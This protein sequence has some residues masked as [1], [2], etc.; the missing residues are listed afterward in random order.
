MACYNIATI[1]IRG[2]N[3][4]NKCQIA[5]LY[6]EDNLLDIIFIQETHINNNNKLKN[7]KNIF[8]N[9]NVHYA[10]GENNSRGV[11]VLFKNNINYSILNENFD[12]DGRFLH[13]KISINNI[14]LNLVNIYAPNHSDYQLDFIEK[15]YNLLTTIHEDLIIGGDFNAISSIKHDTCNEKRKYLKNYE[16]EWLNLFK[17]VQ[18][19][20]ANESYLKQKHFNNKFITWSNNKAASRIDRLYFIANKNINLKYKDTKIFPQS[21]HRIVICEININKNVDKE[22]YKNKRWILNDSILDDEY[23]DIQIKHICENYKNNSD[24]INAYDIFIDKI[25]TTLK[26]EAKYLHNECKQRLRFL[27]N[28]YN[29]LADYAG[30]NNKHKRDEIKNEIYAIYKEKLEGVKKRSRLQHIEFA[31]TPTKVYIEQEMKRG[32]ENTIECVYNNNIEI[33]ENDKIIQHFESFYSNLFDIKQKINKSNFNLPKID[34]LFNQQLDKEFTYE[35]F[36]EAIKCLRDVAPGKNGL[37]LKFYKK[38]FKFFGQ[39][40]INNIIR[41]N[42]ADIKQ[43]KESIIRLIPKTSDKTKEAKDFRPITI[44]NIE[45]KIVTKV[46]ATRLND[47]FDSIISKEQTCGLKGRSIKNN[48]TTLRDVLYDANFKKKNIYIVAL[49]QEKAFDR[50]QHDYLFDLLK[51]VGLNQ[52]IYSLIK[53]LYTNNYTQLYINGCYSI[54]IA[55]MNGIKQGCALSMLLYILCIEELLLRI[56]NN[57]KING[58]K[59]NSFIQIAIKISAY[60]DDT[61]CITT[62]ESSI[63]EIIAEFD[64]W[65]LYSGAKLNK[66]KTSLITNDV[67]VSNQLNLKIEKECKILGV[68]FNYI[69]LSNKNYTNIKKQIELFKITWSNVNISM[70]ERARVLNVFLLSK[71]W[72]IANFYNYTK[73]QLIFINRE[74]HVFLW[75]S[76][77]ERIKRNSLIMPYDEGGLQ[78]VHIESKL[79]AI[80]VKQFLDIT[81]NYE[82]PCNQFAIIYMK[83]LLRK[84]GLTKINNIPFYTQIPP[85]YIQ[86]K[87]NVNKFI[88]MCDTPLQEIGQLKQIY[89]IIVKTYYVKPLPERNGLYIGWN[90]I[91]Y[92]KIEPKLREINFLLAYNAY[93]FL[94]NTSKDKFCSFCK[95]K[96]ESKQHLLFD[97]MYLKPLQ[98]QMQ[99]YVHNI[100]YEDIINMHTININKTIVYSIYKHTI[101]TTRNMIFKKEKINDLKQHLVHS[102]KSHIK[103]Y[104]KENILQA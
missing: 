40:F 44:T 74:I 47:V 61:T 92:K 27:Q 39:E 63:N 67:N 1:N 5:N 22:K 72:F 51:H 34:E 102:F 93:P 70:I 38:Y 19:K 41:N 25:Q 10:H 12:F 97:C 54:M 89:N 49:D 24:K 90:N 42:G 87:N 99:T 101:V 37:T 36:F 84:Y 73:Q 60:A 88:E 29:Q 66:N 57:N 9:Y 18:L 56:K 30:N 75:K 103:F 45:Y 55:I 20:E 81:K 43:L 48:I 3:D 100:N 46:L 8:K 94:K 79:K 35:E 59:I 15:I 2:L 65:S 82:S 7:I 83:F 64:N 32:R 23:I 62:D 16:K 31:K 17:L 85:F 86:M 76:K 28:E 98:Q 58:Y 71:F 104:I 53:E 95:Y 69:G 91:Q 33:K 80:Q 13:L 14:I 78:M 11:F 6:I 50:I 26:R 68:Y 21:D 77:S 4:L 52:K 96:Q